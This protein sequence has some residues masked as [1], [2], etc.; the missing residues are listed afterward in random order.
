VKLK[1]EDAARGDEEEADRI[2][3]A[4]QPD[5]EELGAIREQIAEL[6]RT[7]RMTP[8]LAAEIRTR[9]TE[10]VPEGRPELLAEIAALLP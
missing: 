3:A 4:A 5:W 8:A 7:G 9:A 2:N 6:N 10:A 1:G